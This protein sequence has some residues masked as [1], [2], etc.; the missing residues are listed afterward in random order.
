MIS[1]FRWQYRLKT[2]YY[3]RQTYGDGEQPEDLAAKFNQEESVTAMSPTGTCVSW[4]GRATQGEGAG[5]RSW[6]GPHGRTVHLDDKWAA[7]LDNNNVEKFIWV[8]RETLIA[9]WKAATDGGDADLRSGVPASTIVP[10]HVSTREETMNKLLL[11]VLCL[12]KVFAA[13]AACFADTVNG[14]LA[15][16]RIFSLPQDQGK[17]YVSVVGNATDSRYNQMVVWSDTNASLKKLKNHFHFCPVT[18]DTAVHQARYASNVK[19]LPTVRMQKPDDPWSIKLPGRT[20][21]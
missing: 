4:S 12:L 19:A 21:P 16:Q 18:S 20:S 5:L 15:E 10:R 9:E 3:W 7:I 1:L 14:V 8:P 13:G 2:S 17:W 6:A 11:S